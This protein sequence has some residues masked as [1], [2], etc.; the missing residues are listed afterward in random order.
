MVCT[1]DPLVPVTVS[2]RVE[3]GSLVDVFTVRTDVV[4][5]DAM[6]AGAKVAVSAAV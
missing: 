3:R 1:N 5:P 2:V 6:D 4:A